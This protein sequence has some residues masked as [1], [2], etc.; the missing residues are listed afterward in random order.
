MQKKK[1]KRIKVRFFFLHFKTIFTAKK[2]HIIV[3]RFDNI[4]NSKNF[5]TCKILDVK[6]LTCEKKT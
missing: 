1:K 2:L 6:G 3:L 4:N 5:T